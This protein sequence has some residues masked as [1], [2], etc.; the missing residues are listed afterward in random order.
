MRLWPRRRPAPASPRANPTKIAVL[1]H[2][3]LGILPQPG[4]SAAAVIALRRVGTCLTHQ[5][6]DT[7]T[8]GSP[9]SV[10]VCG[11]CG[12]A[13]VLGDDGGW[14]VADPS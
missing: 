8:L 14:T 4:T 5:P 2:D 13:M 9:Q 6:V 7:T 10:G 3:L 12:A 1:E 11:R